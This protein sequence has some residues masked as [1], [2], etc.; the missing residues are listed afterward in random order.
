MDHFTETTR[1]SYGSNIGNSFKGILFGLLL[2]VGSIVLLWWNESRSVNQADALNEMNAK[3]VTLP[4][5]IYHPEHENKPV[6]VQGEVKPV[7]QIV[8]TLF[9]VKSDGLVLRRSV[10]MYQWKENK[11]SKSE[12]KLGGG[13]ET[14]TT[15]DYVKEWSSMA[16]NSSSFKHPQGHHN[17]PMNYKGE[18]FVTD[19]NIGGYY[20]SQ[21]MV[22]KIGASQTYNGLSSMP[23]KIG[24]ADNH[25]SFLYIGQKPQD[26]GVTDLNGSLKIE[27]GDVGSSP[28]NPRVG[29]VKISYTYAPAGQYSIAAKSQNKALVNYTTS[30]GESFSFIRSGTVSAKQIFKDELDANSTLTWILRGVGLLIMFIGFSLIMGP[31]ATIAKVIPMLGSLVGGATGIIAGVLT[32]VLGSI[33]ISLA[34]F[35][36]RPMLSLAIIGI[37][38]AIVVGLAKFGKKK[39]TTVN[40]D[41]FSEVP[42][43]ATP[44]PRN[45]ATPPERNRD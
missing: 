3:I 2:L 32:L 21:N 29:D 6:L 35:T 25:M 11:S 13:T 14:V 10:E 19:A 26:Q 9:G 37:G 31:L 33:V 42:S 4:D 15:Y 5:S 8:D 20:L 34:W 38:I 22:A 17:P 23:K 12:E 30:N 45:T 28:Q 41:S 1:T 39:E 27:V 18:T 43:S 7:S 16:I 24:V 40:N 36:S 44:P